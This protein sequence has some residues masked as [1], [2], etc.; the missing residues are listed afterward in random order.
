MKSLYTNLFN[1]TRT[2]LLHTQM[3]HNY[4][5]WPRYDHFTK[6]LILLLKKSEKVTY[7]THTLSHTLLSSSPFVNVL[8]ESVDEALSALQ[9]K[10]QR[11]TSTWRSQQLLTFAVAVRE[12]QYSLGRQVQVQSVSKAL[13]AVDQRYILDGY[14]DPRK[15]SPAQQNLDLPLA[16]LLRNTMMRIRLHSQN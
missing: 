8:L 1:G 12:G 5:F 11:K 6:V 13:W 3:Y 2:R 4:K 9:H 10:Q 7:H 15:S 16:H 14:P